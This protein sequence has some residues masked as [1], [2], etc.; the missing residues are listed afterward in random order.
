MGTFG[1]MKTFL[2]ASGRRLTP[3]ANMRNPSPG[4]YIRGVN[5]HSRRNLGLGELVQQRH[6]AFARL[7]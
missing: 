7:I 3:T 4:A 6:A 5:L 1:D 2:K